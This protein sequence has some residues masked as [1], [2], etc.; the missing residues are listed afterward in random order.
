MIRLTDAEFACIVDYMREKFGINLDKKRVLIEC[1][2]S[3]EAEKFGADTF[4]K[5]LRLMQK[6]STGKMADGMVDRLTTNYTYFMREPVHFELLKEKILPRVQENNRT[7]LCNI[8][9]AGCST[10][11]ES[12][13]LAM[14][15]LDYKERQTEFF[16]SFRILGTDISDEV[17]ERAKKGAYPISEMDGIP[18]EWRRKYCH[19]LDKKNFVMDNSIKSHVRFQKQ[20]LMDDGQETEK[21]D[22]IFCRN[23]MIY[24]NKSSKT[25]LLK[26]LENSLKPG[27]YLF[28]GLAELLYREE[29]KL[30]PVYPAIY[31]KV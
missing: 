24:F 3:K 9:C 29:T 28:V 22:I 14:L 6:D 4:G 8:W 16:Q 30:K 13:T 12:Y 5:Y 11:Q 25:K 21:Y 15:L 26:R 10:G 17:L 23:V 2:L 27:G 20:N 31:N 18:P 7:G 19:I 1:R